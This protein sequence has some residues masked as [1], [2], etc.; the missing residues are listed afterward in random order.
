MKVVITSSVASVPAVV[1]RIMAEARD[2]GYGDSTI[3]AVRLALDEA[4]ANAIRHGNRADASKNVSIDYSVGDD[5]LRVAVLDEGSGFDPTGVPDPRVNENL[6]RT[7]GRGLLLMRSY[8]DQVYYNDQGNCVVLV[9]RKDM[10]P[11]R[12]DA[13]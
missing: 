10:S 1:D 5:A 6:L 3:G 9:K 13:S 7:S 8:M 2:K 4:I 11:A 12:M